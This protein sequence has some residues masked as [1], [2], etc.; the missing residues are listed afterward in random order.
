LVSRITCNIFMPRWM[1]VWAMKALSTEP[2][3]L[4]AA[5]RITRNARLNCSSSQKTII[6]NARNTPGHP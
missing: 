3:G 4:V 2:T 5:A 1:R 6:V